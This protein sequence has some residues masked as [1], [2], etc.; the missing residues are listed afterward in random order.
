MRD[1][2]WCVT[3]DYQQIENGNIVNQTHGFTK[4]YGKFILK[5]FILQTHRFCRFWSGSLPSADRLTIKNVYDL[6]SKLTGVELTL[7][8]AVVADSGDYECKASNKHDSVTKQVRIDVQA[9]SPP[10]E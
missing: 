4:E 9:G 6:D 1:V 8:G 3:V 2:L 5:W 7:S 10:G